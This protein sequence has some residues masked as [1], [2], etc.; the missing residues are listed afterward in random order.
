MYKKVLYSITVILILLSIYVI[1]NS[2]IQIKEM[3]ELIAVCVYLLIFLYYSKVRDKMIFYAFILFMV[4][5]ILG[6]FYSENIVSKIIPIIR[7][8]AYLIFARRIMNKFELLK[9]NKYILFF[10][11]IVIT[12]NVLLLYNI[13]LGNSTPLIDNTDQLL[14]F[15]FGILLIAMSSMSVNYNFR[16]NSKRSLY[17]LY[18]IFAFIIAD[19][20]WFI[21][22]FIEQ[23]FSSYLDT[24]AY[25]IALMFMVRYA[26]ETEEKD[27]VL[28]ESDNE[29]K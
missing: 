23:T 5:D 18:F 22:S 16:Y 12:L 24:V 29:F 15:F 14:F 25:I 27:D 17:F 7:V 20:A 11:F 9:G 1:A 6:L 28:L 19:V 2:S 21:A 26:V 10:F 3:V 13:I 8:L 4:T